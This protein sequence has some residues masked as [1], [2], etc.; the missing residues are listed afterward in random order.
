M[1]PSLFYKHRVSQV[2]AGG[3]HTLALV[4]DGYLYA[5]GDYYKTTTS[6]TLP[7]PLAAVSGRKFTQI[8]CQNSYTSYLLESNG[9]VWAF[10]LGTSGEIGN[11]AAASVTTPTRILS[12]VTGIVALFSGASNGAV[13]T[14]TSSLYVWGKNA[15]GLLGDLTLTNVLT[16]KLYV[17]KYSGRTI[18]NVGIGQTTFYVIYDAANQ[19]NGWLADDPFVCSRHGSCSNNAC[20]CFSGY[21]GANCETYSCYDKAPSDPA[22]CSGNG[23]CMRSDYCL[24]YPG[25]SGA[26][27]NTTLYGFVYSAGRNNKYQIGDYTQTDRSVVTRPFGWYALQNITIVSAGLTH[28]VSLNVLGHVHS[29]GDNL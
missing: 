26:K 22:V 15:A 12:N 21:S 8:S 10:G 27:C 20:M 3:E 17:P 28:T 16:P 11:G 2:C 13:L 18:R 6:A 9:T 14:N 23:V 4:D 25:Y 1:E 19:C 7:L 29:W 24:C 5:W